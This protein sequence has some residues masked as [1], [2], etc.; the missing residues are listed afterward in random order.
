VVT[1]VAVLLIPDIGVFALE[2]SQV[3][4]LTNGQLVLGVVR[5]DLIGHH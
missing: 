1:S 5:G 4:I 3:Y 2:F